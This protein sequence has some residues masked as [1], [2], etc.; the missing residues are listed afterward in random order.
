VVHLS[1][2]AHRLSKRGGPGTA[3]KRRETGSTQ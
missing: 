2:H 1:A 3:D